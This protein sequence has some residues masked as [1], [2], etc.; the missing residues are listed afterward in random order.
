MEQ[1][2][3]H[4]CKITFLMRLQTLLSL[5]DFSL[6]FFFLLYISEA[7]VQLCEKDV[8]FASTQHCSVFGCS[9]KWCH[10]WRLTSTLEW[11]EYKIRVRS[12]ERLWIQ[13]YNAWC[14]K[15]LSGVLML[16]SSKSVWNVT[17]IGAPIKCSSTVTVPLFGL[18]GTGFLGRWQSLRLFYGPHA[19]SRSAHLSQFRTIKDCK[20][21]PKNCWSCV[22]E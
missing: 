19:M 8:T 3:V 4:A 12:Y 5:S 15:M 6:L 10:I 13:D 9:M 14:L 7:A 21:K 17:R 1:S 2:P 20:V 18:Q 11:V 22:S 16:A